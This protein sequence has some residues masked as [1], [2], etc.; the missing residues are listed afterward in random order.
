MLTGWTAFEQPSPA[1][2]VTHIMGPESAPGWRPSYHVH[3]VER[4]KPGYREPRAM[5]KALRRSED[6]SERE[7]TSLETW[8]VAR[9]SA[10]LFEVRERRFSPAGRLPAELRALHHFYAYVPGVG[11]DYF[12][13]KLTTSEDE[14][15]KLRPEFRRFLESMRIVGY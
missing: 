4:G 6:A 11:E 7:A 12:I 3:L 9:K 13:V 2:T 14:Y 8:R 15:L 1:G 10:R 5:L